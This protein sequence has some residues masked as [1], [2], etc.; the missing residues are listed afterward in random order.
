MLLSFCI[1]SCNL[2]RS[3]HSVM[4]TQPLKMLNAR[5]TTV[6]QYNVGIYRPQITEYSY[7]NNSTGAEHKGRKFQCLLV[8][9]QN[10][11]QYVVGELHQK[12][13]DDKPLK[14]AST[15]FKEHLCFRMSKTRLKINVKQQYVHT[16][17]KI[18]VDL[19]GTTFDPI[20]EG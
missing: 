1:F 14:N 9:L 13:A 10:R 15:K 6:G 18:V 7:T 19:A 8:C 2:L 4:S 5:T 12:A 16:P 20:L 11:G 3:A 17:Q